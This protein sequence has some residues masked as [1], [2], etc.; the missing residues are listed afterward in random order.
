[1]KNKFFLLT[2]QAHLDL[3]ARIKI[4]EI[5]DR[6][7]RDALIE[8]KST[9]GGTLNTGQI[10]LA[11]QQEIMKTRLAADQ[12]VMRN[13]RIIEPA[14]IADYVDIG[15]IVDIERMYDDGRTSDETY[16]IGCYGS[17]DSKTV[18]PT[19]S[20][21]SPIISCIFGKRV[22]ESG[23]TRVAERDLSIEV[24]AIRLP[25]AATQVPETKAA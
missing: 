22:G 12:N 4:L 8:A 20:Y 1:M 14:S 19:V 24:K 9:H 11:R 2:A 5:E 7:L 13:Y 21:D 10:E 23:E 16:L 17:N 25:A 6:K 15:T 18:P 3:Q